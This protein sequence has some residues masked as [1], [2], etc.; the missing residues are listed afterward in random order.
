MRRT[1]AVLM[2]VALVPT[3]LFSMA[4]R[5]QQ[6][7]WQT[8]AARVDDGQIQRTLGSM[9][10]ALE[11]IRL[12]Y[13]DGLRSGRSVPEIV[14]RP[15]TLGVNW[16]QLRGWFISE[17]RVPAGALL[18]H[19]GR[20]LWSLYRWYVLAAMLILVLQAALVMLLR[21]EAR[22]RKAADRAGRRRR[23]FERLFSEI[24]ARLA[25]PGPGSTA[26]EIGRAIEHLR[27]HLAVERI[28]LFSRIE[29]RNEFRSLSSSADESLD[30][31]APPLEID[32][33]PW[34]MAQLG[35]GKSVLLDTLD[36]LP[37]EAAAEKHML[38]KKGIKSI[39]IVPITT[40]RSVLGFLTL[41][42]NKRQRGWP[43]ELIRQ[44][45]ILGDVFHQ[46]HLRQRAENKAHEME[47]RFALA[48]DNAPVLIW[49]AGIDKM[50]TYFNQG[51]LE[52]TGRTMDQ[53]AGSGWLDGVH[54]EDAKQCLEDYTQAFDA[55][56]RFKLE[57]RLRRFDGE[58]HWMA[59][60]GVPRYEPDGVFCGYIGSCIDITDLK[61]SEQQLKELSGQLIHA[62]EDE[63]K[64]I[65]RELHDDFG[66]QLTLLGLELAR[67]NVSSNR[68]PQVEGLVR[69]VE[70]RIRELSRAMNDLAHQLHSSHLETLGLASAIQGFCTDFS[71]Q[72]E[73]A[74]D[75]RETGI[76]PQIPSNVS[77]C[78]F[79]IVQEGL[80]NVAKHSRTNDCCV[81]LRAE[82]E[83]LVLRISDSGIGFDP[84]SLRNKTG[85][86]L[87]SMRERLRLVNG[88]LRLLS[89][90]QQGTQLE[91]HVPVTKASATA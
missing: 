47:Q 41:T 2:I 14:K 44:I 36:H 39:A 61:R 89:S 3:Q 9:P 23:E 81:E 4:L 5:P 68:E 11:H 32:N 10:L 86:G 82:N 59:D 78:L 53:E 52:F 91:I 46:A 38:Q 16:L 33:S 73:I 74:V 56:R 26:G 80:Q 87:I 75:F 25:E 76:S 12:D 63:R 28:S 31:P 24:T 13:V 64:R 55:R 42:V 71:K 70:G 72:H 54:P 65:A 88:Q 60:Y 34:L 35:N 90:P 18:I 45:Q 40:D 58:Y 85:L 62:Q 77:L 48:A 19:S 79:R 8:F 27:L 20:T 30:S 66:Q 6:E 69:G 84:A 43:E 83:H 1:C 37:R 67:L 50:C 21:M 22:R 51:W 15:I 29:G 57:Y 17:G 7:Q 49:M